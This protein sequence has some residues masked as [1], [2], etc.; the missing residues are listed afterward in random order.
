MAQLKSRRQ[1]TGTPRVPE[2]K[3]TKPQLQRRQQELAFPSPLCST[4]ARK[5]LGDG[6]PPGDG[7]SSLLI[8]R[9]PSS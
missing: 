2:Q 8:Q 4:P 5:A 1:R 9:Q 6:S 7:G 3:N